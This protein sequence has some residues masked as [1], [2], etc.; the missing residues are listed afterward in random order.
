M[1]KPIYVLGIMSGTS[2]DGI[3]YVLTKIS[4][5]KIIHLDYIEIYSFPF[6]EKIKLL[7]KK[8]LISPLTN[9]QMALLIKDYSQTIAKQAHTVIKK[10]KKKVNLIGVHGQT[11]F[12]QGKKF[13]WQ[14]FDPAFLVSKTKTST[15]FNFRNADIS[16]GGQGAPLA[17]LF[18]AQLAKQ[19][20]LKN[21]A[22]LNLGGIANITF[23]GKNLT[24]YDTGPANTLIDTW[25][26]FK[27]KKNF[28]FNGNIAAKGDF[29]KKCLDKFLSDKYFLKKSPKSTGREYFNLN[30]IKRT[31]PD[32]FYKHNLN[33]QVCTLTE[34]TA[35]SIANELSK[36]GQIK[37]LLV[38]GGGAQNKY[39]LSRIQSNLKHIK[40]LDVSDELNWPA[41]AIEGAAFAYLAYLHKNNI[42]VNTSTI[43]GSKNK[44]IL[45][46]QRADY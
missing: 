22:F 14:I 46:G 39:L 26:R 10:S 9:Q 33:N 2:L 25:L 12:H 34:L 40:V 6:P 38:S 24:A 31:A 15:I 17:P 1:E 36:S 42:K 32:C 45:L 3:D 16:I 23:I 28:D 43:T 44:Y 4:G 8:F 30:F 29:C 11:V 5:K 19:F 7:L 13:S 18:H 27:I 21:S 41:Q 37:T 35:K 20:K